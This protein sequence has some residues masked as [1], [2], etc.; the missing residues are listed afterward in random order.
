MKPTA[1]SI[2]SVIRTTASGESNVFLALDH[3]KQIKA[4]DIIDCHIGGAVILEHLM[5]GDDIGVHDLGKVVRFADEKLH[6]QP[7]VRLMGAR[8]GGHRCLAAPTEC[9]GK[10][11]LDH[12]VPVQTVLG[13]IGD[14]KAAIVQKT[15]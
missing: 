13:K 8:T 10:A 14:A 11:F 2:F 4:V 9:V 6:H 1:D 15:W 5:N 3:L 12:D 7:Q